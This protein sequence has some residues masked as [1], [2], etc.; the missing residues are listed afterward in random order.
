MNLPNKVKPTK[1]FV[2]DDG[3]PRKDV[4]IYKDY[5]IC[6]PD[7]VEQVVEAFKNMLNLD[8]EVLDEE[9]NNSGI[10]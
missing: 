7:V 10:S 1:T 3:N 5:L 9:T 8:L 4:A 2:D 6:H